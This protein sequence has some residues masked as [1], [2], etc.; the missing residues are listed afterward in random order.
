MIK[1][2]ASKSLDAIPLMPNHHWLVRRDM[3]NLA[4]ML[5][6]KLFR[7]PRDFEASFLPFVVS[8]WYQRHASLRLRLT[9]TEDDYSPI[10]APLNEQLV[11]DSI[12]HIKVS[13][14]EDIREQLAVKGA[15][16]KANFDIEQG[17][18]LKLVYFDTE[19]VSQRRLLIIT[20]QLVADESSWY[21]L[22]YEM[23]VVFKKWQAGQELPVIKSASGRQTAIARYAH[24]LTEQVNNVDLLDERPFWFEQLSVTLPSL[25]QDW[26]TLNYGLQRYATTVK[27]E[28]DSDAT[29][30]LMTRSFRA[31]H[32]EPA[33][34]LLTALALAFYDWS[35]TAQVRIDM[36]T[37]GRN[38]DWCGINLAK[39]VGWFS[40]AYPLFLNLDSCALDKESHSDLRLSAAVKSIKEQCRG[41]PNNGAGFTALRYLTLAP[42]LIS[43]A[44]KNRSEVRFDFVDYQSWRDSKEGNLSQ[45]LFPLAYGD[46]G[47]DIDGDKVRDHGLQFTALLIDGRLRFE[48]EYDPKA[49]NKVSM[50][51][52]SLCYQLALKA[53]VVHCCDPQNGS[54]TP[55]DFPHTNGLSQQDIE[56]WQQQY[57]DLEQ[58]YPVSPMQMSYLQGLQGCAASNVSQV[59][60]DIS[61]HLD[62]EYIESL[63]QKMIA[64]H[65]I[66][67]TAFVDY[68]HTALMQVVM[69][70]VQWSW[71]Q[72]DWRYLAPITQQHQ[73]VRWYKKDRP[74]DFNLTKPP[75]MRATIFRLSDKNFRCLI[76]FHHG[77]LDSTSINLLI[78]QLFSR[79]MLVTN[80][81][82][83]AEQQSLVAWCNQQDNYRSIK[84]W[85]HKL[86]DVT[87]FSKVC[88]SVEGGE[89]YEKV[90]C[91]LSDNFAAKMAGFDV[92]VAVFAQAVWG[93]VLAKHSQ[94]NAVVFAQSCSMRALMNDDVAGNGLAANNGINRDG[95]HITPV[96]P[97]LGRFSHVLPVVVEVDEQ[98]PIA[99]WFNTL[100][101]VEYSR[102]AHS[103][104]SVAELIKCTGIDVDL[105][106][107]SQVI[108]EDDLFGPLSGF[109]DS[110]NEEIAK[111]KQI[112][113]DNLSRC[114]PL[115]APL[116][117][118]IVL[119][120]PC[121]L[122][123]Y[124]D[125]RAVDAEQAQVWLDKCQQTVLAFLEGTYPCCE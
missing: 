15:F 70:W 97:C 103:N 25:P 106:F 99:D 6:S 77:M 94:T 117:L 19:V 10:F 81:M 5:R 31:Y 40:S 120:E 113:V 78:K 111:D 18:L 14:A 123:I 118:S 8:A 63:W 9:K 52:L 84:F 92:N 16:I 124:F 73:F 44:A 43:L 71:S 13:G 17:P 125:E 34:L 80:D 24:F 35:S 87:R 61:G 41:L 79:Y 54:F 33:E 22:L 51:R 107:N 42:Q 30:K 116:A 49:Y 88:D 89:F 75:L 121:E 104:L 67:R 69:K 62:L 101:V 1:T 93:Y 47:P 102:E 91:V 86:E 32:T 36:V 66:L 115:Y 65:G 57:R 122:R 98:M 26:P 72:Q 3:A 112:T 2:S 82:Q 83:F 96:F 74:Q 53:L 20:H 105:A 56:N 114:K 76:S 4:H 100:R 23:S 90:C 37:D 29:A 12:I 64:E 45:S 95:S 48:L 110:A 108:I 46:S 55:S 59:C 39:T 119:G 27:F 68:G 28:L 11:K 109:V 50:E 58:I 85:R 60:V 21:T 7:L 38:S